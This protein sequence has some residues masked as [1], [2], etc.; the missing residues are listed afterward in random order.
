MV[1][2]T[3]PHLT[4]SSSP[5]CASAQRTAQEVGPHGG[6]GGAEQLHLR[7]TERILERDACCGFVF[8]LRFST[9]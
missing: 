7:K 8:C 2:P 3:R 5:H 9:P 6:S 4:W 1:Q